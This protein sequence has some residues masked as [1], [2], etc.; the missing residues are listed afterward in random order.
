MAT[1]PGCKLPR[2]HEN[3][4]DY[5][6]L[7]LIE[8]TLQPMRNKGITP[9]T[10]TVLS[11][12]FAVMSICCCFHDKAHWAA[13]AWIVQYVLDCADGFMARRFKME[14]Q[15]GD[16]LDH[17]SDMLAF[18][19]LVAF[20]GSRASAFSLKQNWPLA[21]ELV[22]LACSWY[23]MSCQEKDTKHLAITGLSGCKCFDKE[24][25]RYT[26]WVG[27]GTLMVWHVFL[28]YYYSRLG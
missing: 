24:H 5:M 21:I 19:G 13:S 14:S 16:C 27:T 18:G 1:V 22:L 12:V 2:H 26:R 11:A 7:Q 3:P 15:L 25:L 9:N 28:I 10:I 8:P 20:V 23:H 4:L 17:A 6:I